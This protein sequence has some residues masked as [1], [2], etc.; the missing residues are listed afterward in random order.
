M[1]NF[2]T[3]MW[4]LVMA[5]MNT[6]LLFG[7][8]KELS[9]E[10]KSRFKLIVFEFNDNADFFWNFFKVMLLSVIIAHLMLYFGLK[11]ST[12]LWIVAGLYAA[13]DILIILNY[14]RHV[15]KG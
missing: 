5:L 12:V 7:V 14:K 11:D 4:L 8:Y 6:V 13:A 1:I 10:M 15:G 2:M 9:V 3:D